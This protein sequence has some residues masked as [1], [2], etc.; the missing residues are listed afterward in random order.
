[1]RNRVL[2]QLQLSNYN[3]DGEFILECDSNFQLTVGRVREWLK[4]DPELRC[5][6]LVPRLH[7]V[8]TQPETLTAKIPGFDRVKFIRQP[9]SNHAIKTRYDFSFDQM[10]EVL[11]EHGKEY[12]HVYINDP[13]LFRHFKA[14]FFMAFKTN[15][16]FI[17]QNHFVDD[18]ITPKFPSDVSMWHGQVEAALRADHNV[19]FTEHLLDDMTTSMWQHYNQVAIKQVTEKTLIWKGCY[20]STETQQKVD[21]SKCRFDPFL[22]NRE[23][24]DKVIVLVPNRVGGMG[25]SS[26]YTNAGH[27]L[28]EVANAVFERRQDFI[29]IA[30]N[31]N[32]KFSNDELSKMC[33]PLVNLV[34]DTFTRDEYHALARMADINVGLYNK[35]THGGTAWRECIDLGCLP[36]SNDMHEYKYFFDK[37]DYPFRVK[38]DLSDCAEVF[39]KMLDLIHPFKHPS[40]SGR[41]YADE[42][43]E[44]LR[45]AV[46]DECSYE[47]SAQ[48]D[49]K[50]IGLL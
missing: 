31:P 36:L 39:E 24:I 4:H 20:S 48:H 22:L 2:F 30:G 33:K 46:V 26:D 37:V 47:N 18:L 19:F 38:N 49:M 40:I 29:V 7:R 50:D 43:Q 35:D 25:R 45:K 44:K 8:I 21:V 12:T 13:M 42:I 6:I 9:L 32:Q 27:F 11:E 3:T 16:K 5:D 10:E 15:P 14:L 23:F 41:G 17:V 1:M 34:P 28:F